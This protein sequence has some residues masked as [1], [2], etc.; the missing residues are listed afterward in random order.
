M[1]QNKIFDIIQ[2]DLSEYGQDN[3]APKSITKGKGKDF[4]HYE[5]GEI[6]GVVAFNEGH[7]LFC[8]IKEDDD[9]WF[10]FNDTDKEYSDAHWIKIKIELYQ[11]MLNWLEENFNRSYYPHDKK[12]EYPLG[13]TNF[14]NK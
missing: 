12:K 8:D 6:Y 2:E 14:K 10:C 7:V 11:R 4:R 13:F 3:I 1:E 9:N 5:L